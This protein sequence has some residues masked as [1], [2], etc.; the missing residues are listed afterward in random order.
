MR[1]AFVVTFVVGFILAVFGLIWALQGFGVLLGSP[2]SS[3]TTWSITGP[4]TALIGIVIA[5]FSWRKLSPKYEAPPSG[6]H[7]RPD[8]R[9]DEGE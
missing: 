5:I 3:T 1:A 8:V 6:G 2:M 7:R 4:I 9:G